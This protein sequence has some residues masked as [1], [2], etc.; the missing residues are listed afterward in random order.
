MSEHSHNFPDADDKIRRNLVLV[1][2]I[3]L[4]AAFLDI[5]APQVVNSWLKATVP[6]V[7][8]NKI[9]V[10]EFL[11]LLYLMLRLRFTAYF[12]REWFE[13]KQTYARFVLFFIKRRLISGLNAWGKTR[14]VPPFIQQ[15]MKEWVDSSVLLIHDCPAS[16]SLRFKFNY[17][18][19]EPHSKFFGAIQLTHEVYN[20][21]ALV[22]VNSGNGSINYQF[23]DC[24]KYAISLSASL[25]TAFYS[26]ASI[27]FLIPIALG[28]IAMVITLFKLFA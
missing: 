27:E 18:G 24:E 20:G 17:S 12:R 22:S 2:S 4:A 5:S 10:L 8:G 25:A 23:A 26:R 13:V 3:V 11:V 21:D 19:F 16:D 7:S 15:N 28:L 6:E 1:A 9:F 14:L